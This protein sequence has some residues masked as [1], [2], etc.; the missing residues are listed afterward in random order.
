MQI[1]IILVNYNG[2]QYNTACIESILAG[3]GGY[4][5]KIYV[6]DNASRD[7]DRKSVV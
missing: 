2:K 6:V 7:E 1:V 4:E 3:K 5:K